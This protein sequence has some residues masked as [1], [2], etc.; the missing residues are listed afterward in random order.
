MA[1]TTGCANRDN[2]APEISVLIPHYNDKSGLRLCLDSLRAQSFA[3]DKFEI[4]VADNDTPGG[5]TDLAALYPEVRFICVTERG[6]APARNAAM[7]AASGA[8]FAFIDSDCVAAPDWL[9]MGVKGLNNADYSGG[10]I[11]IT[12]ED[13]NRPTP[14]EAFEVVF[15]FRQQMYLN[16]KRFS[17]TANLFVR[18]EAAEAI[19]AF[20]NAVA[21]DLDWGQRADA[22]GF[23]LAFNANSIVSH[24]ARH[25]WNELVRKWDRLVQER[26]NGF[27]KRRPLGRLKWMSLAIATALSA[28]PH[29]WIVATSEKLFRVQDKI[30]AAGVLARIRLWRAWRMMTL[31][32]AKG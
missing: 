11:E 27:E 12:F 10:A 28:A 25:N 13:S 14:V 6:A 4:I 29:L 26:W 20:K 17:A 18:R 8:I 5:V 2:A 3:G 31:L 16:R 1:Y 21:E 23:R 32:G 22:L 9:A 24:P 30:A 15:G 19:G 7:A